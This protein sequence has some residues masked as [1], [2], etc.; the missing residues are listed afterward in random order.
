MAKDIVSKVDR[1]P[2]FNVASSSFNCCEGIMYIN[3]KIIKQQERKVMLG[4]LKEREANS[5]YHLNP[6]WVHDFWNMRQA[7]QLEIN[8]ILGVGVAKMSDHLRLYK[9]PFEPC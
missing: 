7:E 2:L 9:D 6:H 5:P 4:I 3:N 1:L 8:R